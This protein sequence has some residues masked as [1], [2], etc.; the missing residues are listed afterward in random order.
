MNP[1]LPRLVAVFFSIFDN[2]SGPQLQYEVPEDTVSQRSPDE[3]SLFELTASDYVIPKE[4]LCGH[5]VTICTK[6]HKV[7]GFP[8]AV[9]SSTYD[10]N[11]FL[12]NVSFVFD[13][14]AELAAYE[15]LVRKIGRV[16]RGLEVGIHVSVGLVIKTA[17]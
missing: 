17:T 2:H 11:I 8:V 16:L 5:L 4:G 3:P 7:L 12:F 1:S 13:R 14:D 10:R 6:R 9:A 15:P